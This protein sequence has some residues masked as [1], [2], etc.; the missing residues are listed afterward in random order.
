[1]ANRAPVDGRPNDTGGDPKPLAVVALGASAGGPEVLQTLFRRLP[2]DTG[3]AFVVVQHLDPDHATALPDILARHTPIPVRLAVDGDR[4]RP[5]RVYVLPP[6]AV[7]TIRK[8]HLHVEPPAEPAGHRNAVDRFLASLAVDQGENAVAVLL[9]GTGTDG[10]GGLSAVKDHG[11]MT[12]VQAPD[13]APHDGMAVS[14]LATGQV[15]RVLAVEEIAELLVEL[16]RRLRRIRDQ[17]VEGGPGKDQAPLLSRICRV[18]ARKVHYDFSRYKRSTLLRRIDRRMLVHQLDSLDDYLDLLRRDPDEPRLLFRELLIN[19]TAFFRDPEAFEALRPV[20]RKLLTDPGERGRLRIWVPGC[21][22]GEEAYSLAIL[23]RE[24]LERA[25]RSL[26]VQIFATDLDDEALEIAREGR[27]PEAIAERV[28]AERLARFFVREGDHWRVAKHL[29]GMCIF[30]RHDLIGDPPFSRLDLVSCRNLLIYL[31]PDLQQKVVSLL[32]YALRPGGCLFLGPAESVASYGELFR[33]VD[34]KNRIFEARR[35]P[36][37]GVFPLLERREGASRNRGE[38]GRAN[39]ARDLAALHARRVLEHVGVTTIVVDD[40]WRVVDMYGRPSQYLEHRPGPI[41]DDV[42]ALARQDLRLHLRTS[43]HRARQTGEEVRVRNISIQAD[44]HSLH[45]DLTVLPLRSSGEDVDHWIIVLRDTAPAPVAREGAE[46]GAASQADRLVQQLEAELEST[47]QHLQSTIEELETSNEELKASN[48]ELLSVNEELQSSNEELQTSREE[49]Q[50]VNEE[51]ETINA[52]LQK[53][54]EELDRAHADLRNLFESTRIPTVFLDRRMRIK[55]FTPAATEV[56]RLIEADRGRPLADITVRVEG[57]DLLAEAREVLETLVPREVRVR[58]AD[59][60]GP[61]RRFLLRLLPYRTL[62]DAIDGVVLTFVDVTDLERATERVH[63]RERQQAAV[64][65]L[66]LRALNVGDLGLLVQD[67]V[68]LVQQTLGVDCCKLLEL[69]PSGASLVVRAGVGWPDGVVGAARVPAGRESQAGY[70]LRVGEPVIVEDLRYEK[71]FNGPALLTENGIVSGVSCVIHGGERPFGVL[72]A[73]SRSPRRFGEDD[74]HFLVAVAN[75]LASAVARKRTLDRLRES[76]ERSRRQAGELRTLYETAGV[77]LA[78]LDRDLRF[79]RANRVLAELDGV[80]LEAH[81]G[82]RPD[83]LIPT[84]G[85]SIV[86]VARRVLETGEPARDVELTGRTVGDDAPRT[87]LCSFVPL[88]DRSGAA[89]IISLVVDDV[90]E[91]KRAEDRARHQAA[92]LETIYATIPVGLAVVDREHRF[93]KV[94][95]AFA[96][97]T[98]EP[99]EA[100]VGRPI[101]ALLPDLDRATGPLID[102]VFATGEPAL[103]VEVRANGEDAGDARHWLCSHAPIRDAAGGIRAVSCVVRDIT[104][105]KRYEE[106]L[107]EAGRHK[108]EF[109]AMLGHELRNPLA[110]IRAAADVLGQLAVSDAHVERIRAIIERQSGQMAKLVD[111]LL[112]VSRIARGKIRLD[113]QLVDLAAVVRETLVDGEAQIAARGLTLEADLPPEPVW[114]RG[115]PVRLAQVL[116]NLLANAIKFT[117]SPGTVRVAL[118]RDDGEAVVTVRDTGVG[119]EPELLGRLFEPF[120]QAHQPIAR[121]V[122]G[123]GLGLSLVKGLVELHGG[124]VNAHSDGPGRGAEF[125]VRLPLSDAPSA[126]PPAEAATTGARRVLVVDDNVDSATMLGHLLRLAGHEVTVAHDGPE[127]LEQA[128][129]HAPDVIVCDIGLPGG[130]S[131]YEVAA[132]VRADPALSAT[133]LVALTGYG[134][135]EDRQRALE[136]G[137]DAHL[138]KPVELDALHRALHPGGD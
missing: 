78:V 6:D 40:Q 41:E 32:H 119:I 35:A 110:A 49:L 103:N 62:S 1:M 112:D 98:G 44:R 129:A 100:H 22:T 73:H 9:S 105:R 30:S 45:F 14:A 79:V 38:T 91:I 37:R 96:A 3:L 132:A 52:E 55:Q 58:R 84:L 16:S 36:T 117:E 66:G 18:L 68:V 19:V 130:M 29:R 34:K 51:L 67:A 59:D 77:G 75:V 72:G 27:Y 115:D 116:H 92:E 113:E 70:T 107:E 10:A 71:R 120:R 21:A 108:D 118:G 114:V 60:E 48:E 128:R 46:D 64:A 20:L 2:A 126:P 121:T 133:R 95:Q 31:E 134:R 111:G 125:V 104:D 11:G 136:A 97:L 47:R 74:A 39:P 53:K 13:D 15:D 43:L 81:A 23:L 61:E 26:E 25:R 7:M 69:E 54:V 137:F 109:L 65:R 106:A 57:V 80:P 90:T 131:G 83:E 4:V 99:V 138:T 12:I 102:E 17:G 94:N 56:L 24:E 87:W 5:D 50:S 101:A 123:L 76:E 28:G 93:L 127:A 42:V 89:E 85:E 135:P 88:L 8:G 33:T 86:A 124:R 122:G 82:R 63:L